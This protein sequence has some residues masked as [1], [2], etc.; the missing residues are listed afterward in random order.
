MEKID[1]E[2]IRVLLDIEERT[3][4]HSLVAG[5]RA[6]VLDELRAVSADLMKAQ[7]EKDKAR[8]AEEA[9]A[10]HKAA[11]EAKAQEGVDRRLPSIYPAGSGPVES[12]TETVERRI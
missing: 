6:H 10:A 3:R 9:E 5:V 7:E 8:K 12:N 1:Y 4:E 2:H 11:V